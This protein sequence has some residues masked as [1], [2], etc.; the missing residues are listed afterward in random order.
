M[1]PA[2]FPEVTLTTSRE[3]PWDL[4]FYARMGFEVVPEGEQRPAVAAVVADET[5]RG[6]DPA[7]RC[8]MRWRPPR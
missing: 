5:A 2:R 3:V 4:P 8:V 1:K 6:L 7:A